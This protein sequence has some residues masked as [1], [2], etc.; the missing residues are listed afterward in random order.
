MT[1][2]QIPIFPLNR[3]VKI[4]HWPHNVYSKDLLIKSLSIWMIPITYNNFC[5]FFLIGAI[6]KITLLDFNRFLCRLLRT[7]K[8]TSSL[9][10]LS[11]LWC[12]KHW[13]STEQTRIQHDHHCFVDNI[14]SQSKDMQARH[15]CLLVFLLYWFG[16]PVNENLRY[17]FSRQ[18]QH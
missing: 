14:K 12:T 18:C 4:R 16:S 13:P 1:G 15:W 2:D 5:L 3:D 17:S 9:H 6:Y 10:N 8:Q 11:S 7:P